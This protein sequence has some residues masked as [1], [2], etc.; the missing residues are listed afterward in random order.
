M[1]APLFL[2]I[3]VSSPGDVAQERTLA[4]Q[5]IDNLMHDALLR[6]KV[7]L[8]AVAWDKRDSR[9]PMM[10]TLTPQEAIN[11]GMAKPSECEIVVVVLWSR[12]GTPLPAEYKKAD[13]SPYLSGTEYEFEDAMQ[14]ARAC[15]TRP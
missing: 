15:G 11:D 2:R 3:F 13:G 12:M 6:D 1:V 8:K 10:A 5:V 4:H 7:V 14:A 9:T